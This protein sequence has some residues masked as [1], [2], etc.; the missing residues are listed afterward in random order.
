MPWPANFR[1]GAYPK[2]NGS[3]D[4]A[5]YIMSYQVAVA[6]SGGDDA[7]M[8]KSFII[9]LEGPALTWFTR[10][11]PLSIDSWRSLRDKFLLNFQGYRPDTDALATPWPAN[12]RAGTYPKYN[13]STDPAQYIMSYQVAVASAGGDDATMA[14]SFIMPNPKS[15]TSARLSHSGSPKM[16]RS[17]AA[18]GRGLRSQT[19]VETAAVSS[20]CTTSP[21]SIPLL[22]PLVARNIPPRAAEMELV[23]GAEG[24][25]SRRA[26]STAFSTAKTAPTKRK[27]AP[28]RRPPKTEWRGRSQP[29]IPEL[30]RI[31]TSHPLHHI[32]TLPPR[33]HRIHRTTLTNT[34]RR[35]KSYH[36][37]HPPHHAYQHHQEVQVVPPPLPPPHPHQP[38]IH[39]QNHPK[40]QNRKTSLISRIAESFT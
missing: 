19:P 18:H 30:S 6:S 22:T 17:P 10:L 11:P 8:A 16:P 34:I 23:A 25:R 27:T 5:Q 14:K 1:A 2:Y 4:P 32:S 12:F 29:T 3:T 13:G 31:I 36:P 37:H 38:N 28:K 26:G 39:H 35:Y 15:S 20:K 33:I 24:E 9:A 21:T 40:H 7:T